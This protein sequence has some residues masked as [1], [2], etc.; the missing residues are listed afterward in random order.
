MAGLALECPVP[1]QIVDIP[2]D[3]CP[4][5][6]GQI[7]KF[8]I[9]RLYSSG[10]TLNSIAY[11]DA[12]NLA[13]WSSLITATGNTKVQFSPLIGNWLTDPQDANIA[14]EGNETPDGVGIVTSLGKT[15][16][17]YNLL[18]P[19]PSIAA[20]LKSYV[21]EGINLGV[22]LV[23]N[24]GKIIAKA[25]SSTSPTTVYPIP[26]RKYFL[27]DRAVGGLD[28]F[29]THPGGWTFLPGWSDNLVM[30]EPSDFDALVALQGS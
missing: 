11:S 6:L 7:V 22:Y 14:G 15:D 9:T 1:S 25:D 4:F 26:I 28:N 18:Q 21:S 23:N 29:D 2:V 17:T 20:A 27:N 8:G 10:T 5:D 12:D 30:I 3:L 19:H 24:A 13:S 16:V